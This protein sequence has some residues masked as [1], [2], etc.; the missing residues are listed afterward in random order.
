MEESAPLPG[1]I[2][3]SLGQSGTENT[4]GV[5]HEIGEQAEV[6]KNVKS[7]FELPSSDSAAPESVWGKL[8]PSGFGL[9]NADSSRNIPSQSI[10]ADFNISKSL[11]TCPSPIS[12]P[13]TSSVSNGKGDGYSKAPGS[14]RNTVEN[15]G[16]SVSVTSGISSVWPGGGGANLSPTTLRMKDGNLLNSDAT[17]FY[18]PDETVDSVVGNALED[19]DLDDTRNEEKNDFNTITTNIWSAPNAVRGSHSGL[20]PMSDPVNIPQD[21]SLTGNVREV[22][23]NPMS[24]ISPSSLS[25]AFAPDLPHSGGLS[26]LPYTSGQFPAMPAPVGTPGSIPGSAMSASLGSGLASALDLERMQHKCKQWEESWNQAKIACDAWKHEATEANER[27]K[28][29]EDHRNIAVEKCHLLQKQLQ[30]VVE[31]TN[32]TEKQQACPFLHQPYGKKELV[33]L[34]LTSLKELQI[35]YKSD[36]ETVE[37]VIWEL[38]W[39]PQN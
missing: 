38:L 35:K 8:T 23:R 37:K 31:Q 26:S 20:F 34:P 24:S 5:F 28:I 15:T 22:P 21:P 19:L 3:G 10:F 14:E 2:A 1:V 7:A 36:L 9:N 39:Q 13:R 16:F 18:P 25:N 27:A 4:F 33:N 17:P 6:F 29:S 32:S 12:R 11:P 30:L